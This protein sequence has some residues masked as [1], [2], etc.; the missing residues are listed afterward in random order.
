RRL[1][2]LAHDRALT[3]LR[4][5]LPCRGRSRSRSGTDRADRAVV[6][7]ARHT[8]PLGLGQDIGGGRGD[9]FFGRKLRLGIKGVVALPPREWLEDRL[10]TLTAV[11]VS[12][13]EVA[14]EK[15]QR[16]RL[17]AVSNLKGTCGA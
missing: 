4:S 12:V 11:A 15:K 14:K 6:V 17:A 13:K 2:L 10:L 9:R 5:R 1:S 7:G 16:E 3:D 8:T